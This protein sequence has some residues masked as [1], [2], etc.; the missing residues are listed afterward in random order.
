MYP[1]QFDYV[2]PETLD[3]AIKLLAE[4][5]GDAKIL[6]GGHSLLPAMKLRLAQ[7]AKIIDRHRRNQSNSG[8]R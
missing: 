7:P 3:A 2:A 5:G 1:A 8:R 4:S 6:A